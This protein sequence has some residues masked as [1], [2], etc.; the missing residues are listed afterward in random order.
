MRLPIQ[1]VMHL[2]TR[3]SLPA[4]QFDRGL[5]RPDPTPQQ[6][7]NADVMVTG[8]LLKF[9]KNAAIGVTRESVPNKVRMEIHDHHHRTRTDPPQ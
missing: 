9:A 8:E 7:C 1:P 4:G 5:A 2:G 6:F 3:L